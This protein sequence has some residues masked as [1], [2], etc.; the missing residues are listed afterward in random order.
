VI[1]EPS[2]HFSKEDGVH[3]LYMLVYSLTY[4]YRPLKKGALSC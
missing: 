1:G 4:Q 3:V 2:I